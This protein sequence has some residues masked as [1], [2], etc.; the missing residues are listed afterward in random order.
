MSAL[1]SVLPQ[2]RKH[3]GAGAT[4]LSLKLTATTLSSLQPCTQERAGRRQSFLHLGPL[5]RT[6]PKQRGPQT[7]LLKVSKTDQRQRADKETCSPNH[8]L[9]GGR[10]DGSKL[11]TDGCREKTR[12]K[13][14]PG[15]SLGPGTL[16]APGA[17]ARMVA[18]TA[19]AV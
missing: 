7:E 9:P 17:P 5:W 18:R 12:R 16:P 2:L 6:N 3:Q 11:R 14:W 4:L 10:M 8:D 1:L 13:D 15:S 19:T